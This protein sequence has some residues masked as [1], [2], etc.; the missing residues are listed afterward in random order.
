MRPTSIWRSPGFD[1][2]E[3]LKILAGEET[4]TEGHIDEDAAPEVPVTPVSKPG[5]VWIM[6]LHR[7]LCGD[8]A[9]PAS[10]DTLLGNE[11][12]AMIFQDPP[13][14]VDYANSP[15][16]TLRGPLDRF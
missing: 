15:K 6:G 1:A 8:A 5:D 10:Y 7:L 11:R 4:A 2:D 13:Y 3:L 14:N 16:D 9:D 12:V